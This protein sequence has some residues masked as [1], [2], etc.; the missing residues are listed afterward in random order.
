[1]ESTPK[2]RKLNQDEIL[3]TPSTKRSRKELTLKQKYD[4]V[5]EAE[6][7][8]KPTQKELGIKFGIGKTTVSDILKRK[9]EYTQLFEEN[10]TSQ[11]KQHNS[12]SKYGELNDLVFKWFKQARANN[13][14]LN[15][16]IIQEKAM[17]FVTDLKFMDFKA[18]NGLLES[19]RSRFSIGFFKVC[20]ESADVDDNV[21]D[22]FQSKI[23][24]IVEG[25]K[26]EDIFNVD[27]TGLF[28]KALP[29]KTLAPKGEAC[30][31]GK[32]AKERIT[33]MLASSSTGGKLKPLVI[34]KA[35]Q[36]RCFK[37]INIDN[38]PVFCNKK[39]KH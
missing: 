16:P 21:V 1:M 6:K 27:E 10:T 20:G 5:Q 26:A 28:F 7:K 24:K 2:K 30:K 37:N 31:G 33:V 38:L 15:R 23:G 14:P 25:Y 9:S 8:A 22:D 11:R 34:G 4:L 35:K 29:D 32:L 13:I 39:K 3:N 12:G 17:E 36:P 18:S 19:W